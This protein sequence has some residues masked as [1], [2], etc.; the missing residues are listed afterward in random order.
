MHAADPGERTLA[1]IPGRPATPS[2]AQCVGP[3][4]HGGGVPMLLSTSLIKAKS[5]CVDGFRWY[6]R[7]H[8]DGSDYQQVL[9]SLVAAGRAADACWLLDQF[10]PT[11]AVLHVDSL[12]A[13]QLV[14][15][16]SIV[17]RRGIEVGST[18]RAGRAIRCE[19]GIRAG[20]LVAGTAI[21]SAAGI[22]CDVALEAGE[23]VEA[24]WGIEVAGNV[25]CGGHLRARRDVTCGGTLQ[26]GGAIVVGGDLLV[27]GA[28]Q[29]AA[30]L[31]ADGLVRSGDDIR[32]AQGLLSRGSVE[33]GRHLEAGWGIKAADGIAAQ[34][35]IRAGESLA[36]EGEIRAGGGY[37]VFA[38]LSVRR[39]GW[40]CSARVSARTK[41][42]ELLSGWWVDAAA[43]GRN[44]PGA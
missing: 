3:G 36:T 22:R 13:E 37:G 44:A 28:V 4:E 43:V 2:R 33:C 17:A 35:C 39:D 40:E 11:N 27:E 18:L 8:A 20:T 9:D 32:V 30:S 5:P 15:A 42:D 10:G 34:G 19:G 29:C 25:R 38:G 23:E 41:P 26:A 21:R 7:H 1:T 12:V 16:G 24:G 31:R 6:L 14:F